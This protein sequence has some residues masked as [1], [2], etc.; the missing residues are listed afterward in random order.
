MKRR[1]IFLLR[2]SLIKNFAKDTPFD[3]GKNRGRGVPLVNTPD[4]FFSFSD[5]EEAMQSLIDIYSLKD[6]PGHDEE[7]ADYSADQ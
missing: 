1:K 3:F 7:K 6:V 2:K 5:A 4:L